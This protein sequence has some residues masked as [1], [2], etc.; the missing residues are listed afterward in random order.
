MPLGQGYWIDYVYFSNNRN[1]PKAATHRSSFGPKAVILFL[2][3]RFLASQLL[4]PHKLKLTDQIFLAA[5][6]F[7]LGGS[8]CLTT[9]PEN[10]KC[11]NSR[12]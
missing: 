5:A 9:D 10:K 4:V 1:R 6:D 8:Y 3:Y 2:A 7:K 12:H 11:S